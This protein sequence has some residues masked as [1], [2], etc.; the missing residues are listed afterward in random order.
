MEV[1]GDLTSGI[2]DSSPG[3]VAQSVQDNGDGAETVT[4]TDAASTDT[5]PTQ[6]LRVRIAR[7][8]TH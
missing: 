8:V 5:T 6:Y 3:A 4:V 1:S 7:G 2:W